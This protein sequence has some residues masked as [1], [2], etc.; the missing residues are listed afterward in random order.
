VGIGAA[1]GNP[2][3]RVRFLEQEHRRSAD[4]DRRRAWQANLC[5][6][7]PSTQGSTGLQHL[8]HF[9]RSERNGGVSFHTR[10]KCLPGV[11]LKT[12]RNV[13]GHHFR[14]GCPPLP[15]S[16]DRFRVSALRR[17]IETGPENRVHH[18]IPGGDLVLRRNA[19]RRQTARAQRQVVPF[20]FALQLIDVAD[21]LDQHRALQ[22]S[23]LSRGR[24][25]I[26]AVVSLTAHD[27]EMAGCR[28]EL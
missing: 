25:T 20:R 5:L 11:A 13:G 9:E 16:P 14:A 6:D 15:N 28:C 10:R 17:S 22:G 24:Q 3:L 23:E 27:Q 18:H 8:P 12:G 21:H 26:P 4:R 1:F 19:R 2:V 7:E